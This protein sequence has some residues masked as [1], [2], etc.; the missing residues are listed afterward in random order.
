M[1][2]PE[3]KRL[4]ENTINERSIRSWPLWEKEASRFPWRYEDTEECLVLEGEVIV[5]CDEGEFHIGPGDFV[6]FPAGLE[7][8]WDILSP[9]RKHYNFPD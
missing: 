8:T 6:T 7:C 9:I 4:D 2:K 3:I 5:S 1:A